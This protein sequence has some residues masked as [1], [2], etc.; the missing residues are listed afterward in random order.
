ML[1]LCSLKFIPKGP[2][3]YRSLNQKCS[4]FDET[5]TLAASCNFENLRCSHLRKFGP[6]DNISVS[7]FRSRPGIGQA[8][9][10][11]LSQWWPISSTRIEISDMVIRSITKCMH[12][13]SGLMRLGI[14]RYL[15]VYF[16]RL[17]LL[18][19]HWIKAYHMI[20]ITMTS[21]WSRWHLKSPASPLFTQP[22][23]RAPIKENTKAPRHWP[24]CGEFTGDRWIPRTNGQ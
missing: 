23:I 13:G 5:L 16:S 20:P 12:T 7:V 11:Y 2:L 1:N 9:S 24:L 18:H 4:H 21:Y 15:S 6:T 22:F 10:H 14:C 19:W 3:D 8:A 17:V